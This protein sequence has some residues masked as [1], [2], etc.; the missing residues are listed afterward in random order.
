MISDTDTLSVQVAKRRQLAATVGIWTCT[1]CYHDNTLL[2]DKCDLCGVRTATTASK[3]DSGNSSTNNHS[4]TEGITKTEAAASCP[5]CTFINHPSMIQC[6]MCDTRLDSSLSSPTLT[7]TPLLTSVLQQPSSSSSPIS[8]S[9]SSISPPSSPSVSSLNT[10]QDH[11]IQLSFRKGGL[12]NFLAKLNTALSTKAWDQ[13]TS[14]SLA[15]NNVYTYANADIERQ[16]TEQQIR[17]VGLQSIQQRIEKLSTE[18]TV[19]MT[20]AFQDLDRLMAKANEM[21]TLA[22]TIS[23]KMNKDPNDQDLSTLRGYMINLGISNPVTR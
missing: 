3:G 13:P 11:S 1:I 10:K 22:E 15:A 4:S 18:T 5:T 19:T 7:A 23:T 12:G 21:V 20:D 2:T 14:P 6:E 9:S 17:K 16:A 8:I